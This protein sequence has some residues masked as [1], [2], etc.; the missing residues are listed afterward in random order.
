VL[1]YDQHAQPPGR[2]AGLA[3]GACLHAADE[4]RP[5]RG[6][7]VQADPQGARHAA[8]DDTVELDDLPA[9]VEERHR[10][11]PPRGGRPPPVEE[12]PVAGD[13][14]RRAGD[15]R[16]IAAEARGD[17]QAGLHT[18]GR[19]THS[20]PIIYCPT[21][22]DESRISLYEMSDAVRHWEIAFGG[23]EL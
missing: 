13:V 14:P 12:Q 7:L 15:H 1:G 3:A 6:R 10:D 8:R 21:M 9:V 16:R 18:L 22:A 5:P 20:L 19:A 23:S 2:R 4:V 17:R 11:G